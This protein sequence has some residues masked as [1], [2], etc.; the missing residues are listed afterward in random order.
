MCRSPETLEAEIRT[1]E[2][3]L[4]DLYLD[5][6]VEVKGLYHEPLR[7]MN[8]QQIERLSETDLSLLQ[9]HFKPGAE[10]LDFFGYPVG[11]HSQNHWSSLG[12][13]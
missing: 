2:P 11:L 8:A 12:C 7:D 3:T 9:S 4:E 10:L 6:A 1:L 13:G 5:Q